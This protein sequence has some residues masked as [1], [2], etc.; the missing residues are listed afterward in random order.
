MRPSFVKLAATGVVLA[1]WTGTTG[2]VIALT[3]AARSA[4]PGLFEPVVDNSLQFRVK[5]H[6]SHR[7]ARR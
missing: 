1:I 7:S 4:R 3:F 6:L 5:G 2:F